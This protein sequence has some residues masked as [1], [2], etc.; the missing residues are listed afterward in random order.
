MVIKTVLANAGDILV[1]QN[2]DNWMYSNQSNLSV[3]NAFNGSPSTEVLCVM[4]QTF[5]RSLHLVTGSAIIPIHLFLAISMIVYRQKLRQKV[6]NIYASNVIFINCFVCLCRISSAWKFIFTSQTQP[7]YNQKNIST[8]DSVYLV[9]H[10]T[11]DAHCNN[12]QV[13][14]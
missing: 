7:L 8:P 4:K 6:I 11:F 5:S 9:S 14:H 12:W 13:M 1:K 2:V 3:Q 10:G